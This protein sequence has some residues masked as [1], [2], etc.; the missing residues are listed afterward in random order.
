MFR[1]EGFLVTYTDGNSS[2]HAGPRKPGLL[3]RPSMMSAS[4]KRTGAAETSVL[5]VSPS[6]MPKSRSQ[7][8]PARVHFF[9]ASVRF[10]RPSR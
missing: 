6:G 3:N 10:R 2:R 7:K 5:G 8:D 9:C 1:A 4:L